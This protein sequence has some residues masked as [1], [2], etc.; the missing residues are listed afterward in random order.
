MSVQDTDIILTLTMGGRR[1]QILIMHEPPATWFVTMSERMDNQGRTKPLGS[2]VTQDGPD[3]ALRSALDRI[4]QA[5]GFTPQATRGSAVTWLAG[6]GG[7]TQALGSGEGQAKKTLRQLREEHGWAQPDVAALLGL[8]QGLISRWE[9]G[10]AI[11]PEPQQA[12][13]ARLFGVRVDEIAFG[14][15]EQPSPYPRLLYAGHQQPQEP[16][17]DR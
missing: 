2:F 10:A 15:A 16:P 17:H 6:D 8:S 12:R 1:F 13:L 9:R 11:P 4:L 3:V 14:Q 7:T 5:A